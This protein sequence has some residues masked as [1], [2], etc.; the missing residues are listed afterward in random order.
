MTTTPLEHARALALL[1]EGHTAR[2]AGA[3]TG[4]PLGRVV[5]LARRQGWTIHPTTQLATDPTRSDGKP[6]LPEGIAAIL[7]AAPAL[8]ETPDPDHG[9]DSVDQLLADAR[10]CDDR[11]VQAALHRAET[12][13][14]K[15]REVYQET[16]AR[17]AAERRAEQERQ[18]A[19]AEI[20][21]LERKLAA[22]R[23]RAKQ[24]G[25]KPRRR[26]AGAPIAGG[27]GVT[28]R[29]IRAWAIANGVECSPRGRVSQAVRDQFLAAHQEVTNR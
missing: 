21:E 14:R 13:V 6:V 3:A 9:E 5:Q 18:A 26:P 2:D 23:E 24:A 11:H 4:L 28:D 29:A 8:E 15:L 10:D 20:A 16:A 19:L 12:A 25:V 27:S 7:A 1:C 22:A 17:I